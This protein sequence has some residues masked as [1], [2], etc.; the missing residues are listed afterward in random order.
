MRILDG[1]LLP[2]RA[3]AVATAF[4]AA[5]LVLLTGQRALDAY[6]I[7]Q[8]VEGVRREIVAL[9]GRNVTLQAELTGGRIDEDIERVAREELGLTK[10][11]DRPIILIWPEQPEPP[12]EAPVSSTIAEPNWRSWLRLFFQVDSRS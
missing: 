2:R 5:Y 12:A 6:R 11:G 9:R 10:P 7:N 8:E 4:A 3:L 1:S